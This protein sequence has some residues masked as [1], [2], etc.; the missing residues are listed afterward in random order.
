MTRILI[1]LTGAVALAAGAARA[2]DD[3]TQSTSEQ[4]ASGQTTSGTSPSVSGSTSSDASKSGTAMAGTDA[5]VSGD[6]KSTDPVAKV[7]T[8]VLPSGDEKKLDLGSD[9]QVTRDGSTASITQ[10]QPGDNV[11]VSFDPKTHKASK[12]E[13][14][15]KGSKAKDSSQKDSSSQSPSK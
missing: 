3:K 7:I 9:A 5:P 15:S 2:T 12:I 11:R 13:V 10:V 14:K 1:A 4:S 6:V 8:V